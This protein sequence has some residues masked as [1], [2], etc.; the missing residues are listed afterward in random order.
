MY[1]TKKSVD[2]EGGGGKDKSV[3]G[4]GVMLS[5]VEV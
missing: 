2:I 5:A 1:G 4:Y 3:D